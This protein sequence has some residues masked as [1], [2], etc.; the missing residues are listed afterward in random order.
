MPDILTIDPAHPRPDAI[1]VAADV[2]QG[3]GTVVFPTTGLYGI[4]ANAENQSAIKR[5][6]DIKCR[7]AEKPLSI[8]VENISTLKSSVRAI[9]STAASVMK[10]LWPGG[11]TLIFEVSP[12]L[13]LAL[14]AGSG[15]IGV[16]VPLHPVAASLV[17]AVG[18]PITATSANISGR[19][20]CSD[21]RRLDP[22]ISEKADLI[23]DAGPLAGGPG[24]TVLDVTTDPARVLREGTV[25][26]A[27]L[28]TFSEVCFPPTVSGN[29]V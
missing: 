15:K 25:S 16:R 12:A 20:G 3:G 29:S 14:T 28:R 2:I 18:G 1:R 5:V 24:S 9:S 10:R 26:A 7:P 11:V 22:E 13:P 4:A 8:L 23:L 27:C 6:F 17:K 21:I 19:P